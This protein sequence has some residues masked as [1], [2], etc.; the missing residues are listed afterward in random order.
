[1]ARS[2]SPLLLAAAA[3]LALWRGLSF[4]STSAPRAPTALDAEVKKDA[5]EAHIQRIEEDTS[6]FPAVPAIAMA[7][8]A[9]VLLS[10][11]PAHAVLPPE[12]SQGYIQNF[13]GYAN[14]VINFLS[15]YFGA[16]AAKNPN[17]LVP[18]MARHRSTREARA[19]APPKTKLREE[20]EYPEDEEYPEYQ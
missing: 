18:D 8:V 14:L 9:M 7:S 10:S 15:G 17:L 2:R 12:E 1:M 16:W 3:C 6:S 20:P 19:L 5:R 4:V 11:Q 13:L